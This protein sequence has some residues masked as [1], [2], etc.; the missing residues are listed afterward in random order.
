MGMVGLVMAVL[1]AALVSTIGSSLN[2]LST[3]FTMDIYVKKFKPSAS[4]KEISR[5]GYLVTIIGAVVSIAITIAVDNIKGMDLFNVFQSVLSFIAPPMAA[6]F[7]MGV[8]W[9]RC[10]TQA[11]NLVLSL[12]T[13]LSI[14]TGVCYLWVIPNAAEHVHF[15]M[16]SFYIFC[17]L[18]IMMIAVSMADKNKTVRPAM[19]VAKEKTSIGVKVSWIILAAVMIGLYIFFN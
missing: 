9:K 4:A 2:A 18:I 1:T 5:M 14:T 19:C 3:V 10:T 12:G 7:V 16:L 13:F 6:V 11:A 17:A 8:F 15:M